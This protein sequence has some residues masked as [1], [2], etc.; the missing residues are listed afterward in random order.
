MFLTMIGVPLM[1]I[2]GCG[3][4]EKPSSTTKV[5]ITAK[6]TTTAASVTDA[7]AFPSDEFCAAQTDLETAQD[8]AQRNTAIGEMQAALGDDAPAEVSKALE[9]LLTGDLGPEEYTA[10][11]QTLADVCD[12][13][14]HDTVARH[15]RVTAHLQER[16]SLQNHF[17]V[18]QIASPVGPQCGA[19]PEGGLE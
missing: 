2:V 16:A 1:V 18:Q 9:T 14:H 13:A 7:T 10:A 19:E 17:E 3:S 6:S 4:D 12:W 8:G 11:G 5:P 15:R